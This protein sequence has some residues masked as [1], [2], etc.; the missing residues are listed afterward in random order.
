MTKRGIDWGRA[1]GQRRMS[2]RERG[3]GGS[4]PA[5][6]CGRNGARSIARHCGDQVL[7]SDEHRRYGVIYADPPWSFRNWSAKGTGRNAVSHYDCLNFET[8]AAIPVAGL[9]ADD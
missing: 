6:R 8:L 7:Q 1:N 9:A 3:P 5:G 4:A 2:D